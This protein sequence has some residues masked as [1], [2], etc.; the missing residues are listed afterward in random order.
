MNQLNQIIAGL[1]MFCPLLVEGQDLSIPVV[2]PEDGGVVDVRNF[3]AFPDDGVDDTE[4]IQ[5][6]LDAHPNGNR[7]IYLPSG[8]YQVSDTLRWPVGEGESESQKRTILQGAGILHST[9]CVPDGSTAFSGSDPRPVIWT[10]AMPANHLRNAV[11]DLKIMVGAENPAAVGL[12][13]NAS[14]Q[15]CIRNVVIEAEEDSGITGLDLGYTDEIGSLLVENIAV[16]GFEYGISTKWPLNS[17]TFENVILRDQRR[18]GWWNYHQMV[19]L[20]GLV[21]HNWVPAV[22]NEKDS[23]GAMT[24]M[25]SQIIGLEPD[26]SLPGIA[27]QRQMYFRNVEVAG[28]QKA[29]DHS[30]RNRAQDDRIGAAHLIEDTSHRNVVSQFRHL[31]DPTFAAA[32]FVKHLPV[33]ETPVV[34]WGDPVSSWINILEFGADPT[35][36]SDSTA[37]LQGAIDSGAETI[38]LP[39][40]S[41][42]RFEGNLKIRGPVR[43][44]IGLEGSCHTE[45]G[46]VWQLVDGQHPDGLA[47]ASTVVIERLEN[48]KGLRGGELELVIQSESARTL[49]VSSVAGARVF[50]QGSGDIFLDDFCGHLELLSPN[51]SAWC[52]QITCRGKGTKIRNRGGK[53]WI[54]GMRA[55]QTGTLI[56]TTD[57]GITDATG[58]FVYSNQGWI[59]EEPA[60]LI[61]NSSAVLSGIS[62]RNFNRRPVSLWFRETQGGETREMSQHAWVYLSK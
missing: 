9:I 56:E 35:G 16:K 47:D 53:L 41:R 58:I 12:Q 30:D 40:G 20:R 52:R 61:R 3:G 10:G 21:S 36:E 11:R 15:G 37:A 14:N 43:R 6:A 57:G 18:L 26:N 13:F 17:I 55:E 49:V 5:S 48:W 60:F 19:F 62:E 7:I 45:G 42:F 27:N 23:W 46:A 44:I 24:L 34:H 59:R 2:F 8:D 1:A 33:K 54:L 31:D 39:G 22:Y 50:G 32:G 4:A 51:Q 29:I 28:Y 38:Y 25:D